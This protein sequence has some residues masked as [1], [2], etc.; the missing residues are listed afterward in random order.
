VHRAQ[1]TY[2][3]LLDYAELDRGDDL[4][5]TDRLVREAKVA[6][7]PLSVFYAQAPAMQLIRVCLAKQDQTLIEAARRLREYA[8]QRA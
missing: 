7:I 6:T 1:G 3:Q 2:F 4:Q 5:F 8:Q